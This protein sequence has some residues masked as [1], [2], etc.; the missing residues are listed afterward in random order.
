M[1][2]LGVVVSDVLAKYQP[3]VALA[4]DEQPIEGLVANGLDNSFTVGVGSRPPVGRKHHLG[5]FALKHSIEFVD[6][7]GISIVNGK[8]DRSLEVVQLPAQVRCLLGHPGRVGMGRAVDVEDAPAVDLQED[9]DVQR[10]EQHR[11][12][13]EEG[14]G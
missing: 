4:Q 14:A 12:D 2:P 13:G 10:P 3:Q 11:V 7:L 6:E 8:L 1:G 5:A 9:Q